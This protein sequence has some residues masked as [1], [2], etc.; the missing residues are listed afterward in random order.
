MKALLRGIAFLAIAA[1]LGG[2][3]NGELP[4]GASYASLSGTVIDAATNQPIAGAIVTIDTVLTVTSDSA[5]H[6]T[7]AKIPTGDF[8]YSVQAPGYATMSSS[9][10]ATP[11]KP[12][13]IVVRLSAQQKPTTPGTATPS[14][15][16]RDRS[17][18]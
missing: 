18:R 12:I 6:F 17:F 9:G 15:P 7:V 14:S 13:A 1:I 16:P 11:G 8:D 3:N 2:C 4:P 10:S 5:G